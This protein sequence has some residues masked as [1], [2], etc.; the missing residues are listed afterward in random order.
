MT[1]R[2]GPSRDDG[3]RRAKASAALLACSLALGACHP[4]ARPGVQP[5]AVARDRASRALQRDI[6]AILSAPTLG[7]GFWGVLVRSLK[8]DETLYA[9]NAGRL[10]MPASNL[11]I[12]TLAAAA[13]RL[14]WDFTYHTRLL[15]AGPIER[16][17][18][19]G[20]LV[21]VG[22]GDPSLTEANSGPVFDAW[23][24]QLKT[25]GV[26][27]IRGR[28]VGDDR[29]FDDEPLGMG[30]SWDDLA[31]GYATGVGALQ[32]NENTARIIVE[33]GRD[34]GAPAIVTL[35]PQT[36]GLVV[37]SRVRTSDAGEPAAV[38]ARR[39]PGSVDLELR[40]SIPIGGNARAL[41]VSVDKPARFFA[42]ALKAALVARGIAVEGAAVDVRS[43][44]PPAYEAAIIIAE[45]RSPPLSTLAVTLM[46]QS[47]NLYA[48]TLLKTLGAV[49][50]SA[51]IEGGR[52]AL[53]AVLQRWGIPEGS[54]IER[55]GSGLSRYNYVTPD[56]L[57]AVL[58]HVSRDDTLRGPFESALP[59]AGRDGTLSNRMK[60][61]PA[62]GNV[63]AKTGSMMNVRGWSGYVASADGEPLV[64]SILANNFEVAPDVVTTAA[65]RI[66]VRLASFR[67]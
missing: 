45:H 65:D 29:A 33:P 34:A 27:T 28:V 5:V 22:S 40:G 19:E 30:W 47:Q 31:D 41:N 56:A 18:L 38:T 51:T 8:T 16:G 59:V 14:G 11:K 4:P 3:H 12:V 26:R 57:V 44:E 54:V 7:R 42:A 50:G 67:R 37:R 58:S 64:F 52:K 66:I 61:T 43:I 49:E 17:A 1:T 60:A 25:A 9:E 6:D 55:D 35:S 23:A 46:K 21:V 39:L 36:S 10:M 48:E 63:R 24:E 53:A 2:P 15:A 13:D 62:E 32:Y 20:D